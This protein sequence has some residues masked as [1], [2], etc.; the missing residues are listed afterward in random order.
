[1]LPNACGFQRLN[2]ADSNCFSHTNLS[3][4]V[5]SNG[6]RA[7]CIARGG[8]TKISQLCMSVLGHKSNKGTTILHFSIK[9]SRQQNIIAAWK[10]KTSQGNQANTSHRIAWGRCL[11]HSCTGKKLRT[12]MTIKVARAGIPSSALSDKRQWRNYLE[13]SFDFCLIDLH[14]NRSP[15]FIY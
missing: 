3:M 9:S 10:G 8:L 15:T 5:P 1:M 2:R 12:A 6:R 13:S 4:D 14:S 11:V 7:A